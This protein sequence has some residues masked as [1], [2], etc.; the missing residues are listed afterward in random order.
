MREARNCRLLVS[1]NSNGFSFCINI[2]LSP[3]SGAQQAFSPLLCTK[4]SPDL[5]NGLMRR[6][7]FSK[8][9]KIHSTLGRAAGQLCSEQSMQQLLGRESRK[10][11]LLEFRVNCT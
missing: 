1:V 11:S 2:A 3:Y 7:G 6:F 4:Y 9:G 8:H 5:K 10:L